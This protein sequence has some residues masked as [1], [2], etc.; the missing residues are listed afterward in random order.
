MS[1]QDSRQVN[2]G[3][4]HQRQMQVVID[5]QEGTHEPAGS[6]FKRFLTWFLFGYFVSH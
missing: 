6:R 2:D 5:K 4:Q 3:V 1:Y